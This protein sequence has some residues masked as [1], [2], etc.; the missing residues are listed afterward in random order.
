MFHNLTIEK[1]IKAS[2]TIGV[3]FIAAS[4]AYNYLNLVVYAIIALLISYLL[5][6]IVNRMQA[7]GMN[8]TLAIIITLTTVLL[9][10]I[11]GSTTIIPIL[12]NQ[13]AGLARQLTIENIREI[14]TQIEAVAIANFDF[15]PQGFLRNNIALLSDDF[16]N[17]G[18]VS[19]FLGDIIGIFTNLFAAFLIIPFAAFFFLKD[20]HMLRR[21]LLRLVPNAYFE[22]TLSL[23]DKIE[24]RL[25]YYFRSVFLQST[26]VGI[27]SWIALSMAGL[28][29][30]PSVGIAIGIANSIPYFG[31]IIGYA[32]S[33]IISI[34]ETGDFSLVL[35]C[36]LAI[37]VVQI[38]DN[39]VFQPLIF[40]KSADMHPVA[41]LFIIMIG[42]QTAGI[43][44]MLVAIPIATIIKISIVQISWSYHNYKVFRL[45]APPP[46]G[47]APQPTNQGE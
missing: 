2:I 40:S 6:P 32:L 42:A 26:L 35:A 23:I 18:R 16:F 17:V 25:G 5:D 39:V 24:T 15:L 31:P 33:I 38:L 11:W 14:A 22:T 37:L 9:L 46:A 3:L 27:A 34:V 8:R 45:T 7:A 10:I 1:V 47:G 19:A 28:N 21:D 43:I 44:G 36:I 20:G 29:N 12:G 41:I 4:L 30:A 13:M